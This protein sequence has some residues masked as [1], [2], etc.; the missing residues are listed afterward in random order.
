MT[1]SER[2]DLLICLALAFKFKVGDIVE[3]TVA[4]TA[5][6]TPYPTAYRLIV[7]ARVV[8]ESEGGL[9]LLYHCSGWARE[10]R[11]VVPLLVVSECELRLSEPFA[12]PA[13][14]SKEA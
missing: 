6:C 5:K 7:V 3:S 11:A 8:V 2:R 12:L 9:E 14:E 13:A 10:G 1:E 4:A